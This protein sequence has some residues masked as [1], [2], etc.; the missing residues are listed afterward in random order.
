[1]LRQTQQ[2]YILAF[3]NMKLLTMA[4]RELKKKDVI[5]FDRMK[6]QR[7]ANLVY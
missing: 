1:M 2:K 7:L 3:E 4:M 6:N 5:N